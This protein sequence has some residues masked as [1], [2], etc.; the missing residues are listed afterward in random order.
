MASREIHMQ[1]HA[2]LQQYKN[3][4]KSKSERL[5]TLLDENARANAAYSPKCELIYVDG[6]LR[7]RRERR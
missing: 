1:S 2:H 5:C 4:A 3:P 6:G 7:G